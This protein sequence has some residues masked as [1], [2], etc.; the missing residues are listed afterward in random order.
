MRYLVYRSLVMVSAVFAVVSC[1]SGGGGG[2]GPA[3]AP[4]TPTPAPPLQANFTSIQDNVFTPLCTSCHAGAT[5]PLGLRLDAANSFAL[6]VGVNSTQEPSLQRV[7]P[8][9]PNVSYLINKL[10][11]SLSGGGA[12]TGGRMPLGGTALPQADIDVV[13]QWITDGAL[14]PGGQ[15][16]TPIQ[17]TSLSPL[18]GSSVPMLPMTI[19]AVFDRDL[20]ANTVDATTFLVERSG[21]DGTFG[22]GNEIAI[23]P[24]S[25]TVPAANPM[26]AVLDMTTSPAVA[27]TYRVTLVGTG[28]A[29][30][31]LSANAL[32]GEFSGVFPSGDGTAGGDF[33]ADFTVDGIQPTLT[34]IQDNVFT[35]ICSGCHSGVGATLPGVMDLTS[36][37]ASFTSLVG[38]PS[39]QMAALNRVTA[40]DAD[41]SYIVNKLEGML[42][43]G[44]AIAGN[45]MPPPLGGVDTASIAA[46]RQWITDGALMN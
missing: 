21:G 5:A 45:P 38:T 39:L 1:G 42:A 6:L 10:E 44:G 22:D 40:M 30:L 46:I 33:V 31:D 8:G 34:S 41:N 13:R 19:M 9:N 14:G 11:G 3:A 7:D 27:D 35:P 32:D 37:A 18:P 25:V 43:G 29:I 4:P 16:A 28:T 2:G 23:V 17:V 36:I 15:P 24:V 20:D 12:V 26:T